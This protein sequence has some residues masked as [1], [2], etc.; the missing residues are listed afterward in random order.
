[1]NNR[2]F[3]HILTLKLTPERW[4]EKNNKMQLCKFFMYCMIGLLPYC[5]A[6]QYTTF[7]FYSSF[8][9]F[10]QRGKLAKQK[11]IPFLAL[12]LR[13]TSNYSFFK[14]NCH[15]YNNI[16]QT[17]ILYGLC[18]YSRRKVEAF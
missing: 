12:S 9:P 3:P 8:P 13:I 10:P 4:N 18:K 1:M 17:A 16:V 15:A 2:T 6:V 7:S 14:E 5:G 11:I